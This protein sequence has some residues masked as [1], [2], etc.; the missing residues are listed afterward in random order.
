MD[1]ADL[2]LVDDLGLAEGQ[3]FVTSIERLAQSLF[4]AQ[5]SLLGFQAHRR[6]TEPI[7]LSHAGRLR[8]EKVSVK[9]IDFRA[10][11]GGSSAGTAKMMAIFRSCKESRHTCSVLP[12]EWRHTYGD[13]NKL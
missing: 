3:I 1:I 12:S 13:E 10:I 2:V 9:A 5:P 6:S 8:W 11:F 4:L 7:W